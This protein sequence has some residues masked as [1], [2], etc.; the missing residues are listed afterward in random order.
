MRTEQEIRTRLSELKNKR[1][2]ESPYI[3]SK[4]VAWHAAKQVLE[5]VLEEE[6]QLLTY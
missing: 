1:K 5:W 3:E 6:K 4:S 2:I